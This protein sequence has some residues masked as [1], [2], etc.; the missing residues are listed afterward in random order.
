MHLYPL[1]GCLFHSPSGL[2]LL[3]RPGDLP[4]SGFT[5]YQHFPKEESCQVGHQ[6]TIG[7][8]E[9]NHP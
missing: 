5:C 2:S 8:E 7:E 9:A 4:L 3:T 1:R 6:Q